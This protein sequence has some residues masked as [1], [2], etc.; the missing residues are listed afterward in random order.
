LISLTPISQIE[1]DIE[2]DG[3]VDF[4]GTTLEGQMFNYPSPG[5]FF[6]VVTVTD[7]VGGTLTATAIVQVSDLI[8]LDV[9]L[10]AKWAGMK[11]ALRAGDIQG[12]LIYIA[13]ESRERY[14]EI[15]TVISSE[16]FQ[17]DSF[18]TDINLLTVERNQA[19]FQMLRISQG[20]EV[21]FYVLFVRD[22]DGIWRLRTF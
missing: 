19:E 14:Q 7:D 2:G 10:Q 21:S 3:I 1:V 4:Q 16:L 20:V 12:A 8:D 5:L 18:L 9:M 11:D 17:I 13:E 6:P 15:F 22:N